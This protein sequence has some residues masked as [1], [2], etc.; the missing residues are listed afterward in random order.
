[1]R[2]LALSYLDEAVPD[3]RGESGRVERLLIELRKTLCIEGILEIL[4]A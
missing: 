2:F 3:R 4:N 1:M